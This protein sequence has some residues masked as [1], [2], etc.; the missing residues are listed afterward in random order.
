M[1]PSTKDTK[2]VGLVD[3]GVCVVESPVGNANQHSLAIEGH[4]Q[5]QAGLHTVGAGVY[6]RIVHHRG[7][8]VGHGHI[9]NARNTFQHRKGLYRCTHCDNVAYTRCN[10]YTFCLNVCCRESVVHFGDDTYVGHAV[11]ITY[12]IAVQ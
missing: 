4:R 12:W 9:L 6:T 7:Y 5:N 3:I 11:L 8:V 1:V 2:V 10:P